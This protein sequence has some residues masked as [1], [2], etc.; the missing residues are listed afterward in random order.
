M[1]STQTMTSHSKAMKHPLMVKVGAILNHPITRA[2]TR[3]VVSVVILTTTVMFMSFMAILFMAAR[4][5][6]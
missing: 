2:I 6:G 5:K 4:Y 3:V 1:S